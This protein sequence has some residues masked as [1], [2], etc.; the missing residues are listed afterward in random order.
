MLWIQRSTSWASHPCPRLSKHIASF[1]EFSEAWLKQFAGLKSRN[2]LQ[3]RSQNRSICWVLW[4][5]QF[6]ST[7]SSCL[8]R[9]PKQMT[10]VWPPLAFWTC[11]RKWKQRQAGPPHGR[12]HAVPLFGHNE[13][14]LVGLWSYEADSRAKTWFLVGHHMLCM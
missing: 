1:L 9:E 6:W 11:H 8:F 5:L 2:C 13:I 14:R 12:R 4:G 3:I 10:Q 7:L